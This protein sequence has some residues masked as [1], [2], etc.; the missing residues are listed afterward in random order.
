MTSKQSKNQK[1]SKT[2]NL[3]QLDRR[4]LKTQRSL[5]DAVFALF[6]HYSWQDITIS[7]ICKEAKISRST[8]YVHFKVKEELLEKLFNFLEIDLTESPYVGR[9]LD[10]NQ[11]FGF[12]P[13]I[14]DN[15][16][17]LKKIINRQH[18]DMYSFYLVQNFIRMLS[19]AMKIEIR[20]SSQF[21]LLKSK[22]LTMISAALA[23]L[24]KKWLDD[25]CARPRDMVLEDFD[26]FAHG[27]LFS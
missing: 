15:I 21:N 24:I 2:G 3:S 6:P 18:N 13:L 23:T 8:F 20:R 19:N 10:F 4:I 7:M 5:I 27:V 12:V 14:F 11:T 22:D 16:Q 9:G 25:N 26:K 1:K 17:L